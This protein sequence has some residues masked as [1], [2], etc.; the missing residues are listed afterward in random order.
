LSTRPRVRFLFLANDRALDFVNTEIKGERGRADLLQSYSDLLQW[1]EDADVL[2]RRQIAYLRRWE[3]TASGANVLTQARQLRSEL[4]RAAEAVSRGRPM[5]GSVLNTVNGLLKKRVQIEQLV[6]KSGG[7]ERR[8]VLQLKGAADALSAIA[9]CAANLLS[10]TE[11]CKIRR[12]EGPGCILFF[13]DTTRNHT[14]RWCS[15]AGCGNRVK[16]AE[17]RK[18][19]RQKES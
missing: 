7:I 13:L 16:A 15:M 1:L 6:R 4:R 8:A 9:E 2:P 11:V 19:Q 5:H 17:F 12:C 18:R 3:Q 14:R 10:G